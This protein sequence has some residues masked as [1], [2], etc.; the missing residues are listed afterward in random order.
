MLC[1]ANSVRIFECASWFTLCKDGTSTSLQFLVDGDRNVVRKGS[2]G[3]I[4]ELEKDL[5]IS[6]VLK[7]FVTC[8][9]KLHFDK[10]CICIGRNA[11]VVLPKRDIHALI[12]VDLSRD[13]GNSMSWFTAQDVRDLSDDSSYAATRLIIDGDTKVMNPFVPQ[14]FG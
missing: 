13:T 10:K 9:R 5:D 2:T 4:V 7:E 12:Y 6:T 11:T 1:L 3:Q 8:L 14:P